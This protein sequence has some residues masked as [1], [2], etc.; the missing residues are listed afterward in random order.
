MGALLADACQ[1]DGGRGGGK[2]EMA[3]GGGPQTEKL[4]E[5][6]RLAAEKIIEG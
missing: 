3:Q 2:P 4:Y 5:A 6:I 1:M